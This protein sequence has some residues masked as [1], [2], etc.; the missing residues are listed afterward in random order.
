MD[1]CELGFPTPKFPLHVGVYRGPCLTQCYVRPHKYPCQTASHLVNSQIVDRCTGRCCRVVKH[2]IFKLA[3]FHAHVKSYSRIVPKRVLSQ[4][5]NHQPRQDQRKYPQ[6]TA[7]MTNNRKWQYTVIDASLSISGCPSLSQSLGDIF[8][9]F[10]VVKI[11]DFLL[12]FDDI[13]IIL[14]EI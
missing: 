3:K 12:N 7:T 13:Y 4:L 5:C 14:S 10:V 8:I 2:I 11:A 1:R 6:A 9:E